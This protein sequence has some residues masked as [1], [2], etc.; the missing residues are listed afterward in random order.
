MVNPLQNQILSS[1]PLAAVHASRNNR[2]LTLL[3][4]LIAS[5]ILTGMVLATA[6][7]LSST[8][9]NGQF[10]EDLVQGALAADAKMAEILADDYANFQSYNGIDEAPGTMKT[11]QGAAFPISFYRIGRRVSVVSKRL[12]FGGLGGYFIDGLQITI[13]A[14]DPAGVTLFTESRFAPQP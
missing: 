6:A 8:Q 12:T 4:A 9:Q 7:A 2:G 3:E 11:A 5:V 10:A 1:G 14:Y 13:T